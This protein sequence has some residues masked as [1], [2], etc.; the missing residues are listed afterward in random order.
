MLQIK[1][2][3]YKVGQSLLQSG[4]ATTEWDNI[5]GKQ[6][7]TE[8]K[9]E[10]R[11]RTIDCGSLLLDVPLICQATENLPLGISEKLNFFENQKKK[12]ITSKNLQ[13]LWKSFGNYE[14]DSRNIAGATLV[15]SF[16]AVVIFLQLLQEFRNIFLKEHLRKVAAVVFLQRKI[17][18]FELL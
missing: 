13:N 16:S 14:C 8:G 9:W 4:T 5:I 10:K 15:K 18:C 11:G 17:K 12:E 6:F 1:E 3:N 7:S 2:G